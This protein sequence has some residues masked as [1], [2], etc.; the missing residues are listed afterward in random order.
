MISFKHYYIDRYEENE[1]VHSVAAYIVR[2]ILGSIIMMTG[3]FCDD[4][5][6]A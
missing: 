6:L 5:P 2:K 3:I 1:L 4:I